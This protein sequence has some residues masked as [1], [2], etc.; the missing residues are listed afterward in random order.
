MAKAC[1]DLCHQCLWGT[2]GFGEFGELH[3]YVKNEPTVGLMTTQ[4]GDVREETNGL[5]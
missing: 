2:G 4:Y 3:T 5:G 1:V